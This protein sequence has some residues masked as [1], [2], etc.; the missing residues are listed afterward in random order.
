MVIQ[1]VVG[2]LLD[3][4]HDNSNDNINLIIKLQD[5][6]VISFKQKLNENTFYVLPKS[7]LEDV[8]LVE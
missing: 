3:V 5:G 4:S 6:K 7:Q 2:W 1:T 8:P